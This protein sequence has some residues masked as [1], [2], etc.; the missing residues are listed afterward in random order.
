M[1]GMHPGEVVK[2]F[3]ASSAFQVALVEGENKAEPIPARIVN[4]HL[5]HSERESYL[6]ASAS[7]KPR[8]NVF[9]IPFSIRASSFLVTTE[10][11]FAEISGSDT[12]PSE[13]FLNFHFQWS[14]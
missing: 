14:I 8:L 1:I 2:V 7:R 11:Q 12:P 5:Y 10:T 6:V 4:S 3:E 9:Y 13:I